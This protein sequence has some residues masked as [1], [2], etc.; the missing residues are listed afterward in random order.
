MKELFELFWIFFKIGAFTFGGGYA[1]IPQV[2]ETVVEKKKWLKEDEMIDII[3][4]A[5]ST[6]GP[7]VINT[8]TYVGYLRKGIIGSIFATFGVVVPSL[9]IIFVISLFF[10]Q[11]MSF[12]YVKYAFVGIKCAVAI[13]VFK[14]GFNMFKKMKKKVIPIL[15]MGIVFSLMIVFELLSIK[16][17]SIFFILIGGGIGILVECIREVIAKKKEA[18][19][20]KEEEK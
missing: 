17:S 4:I 14:A 20:S 10:D 8:A 18:D 1:M 16:F 6:P 2:T 15:V 12:K 11:F 13:L 7:L 3:A 9:V 5:E 19:A